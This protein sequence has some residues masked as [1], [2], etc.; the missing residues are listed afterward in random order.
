MYTIS[1]HVAWQRVGEEVIIIELKTGNTLG[2]NPTASQ[3]WS[4]INDS[5]LEAIAESIAST[6]ELDLETAT[7]D[8]AAFLDEM[9]QRGLVDRVNP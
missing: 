9:Q 7:R 6:Y 5:S 4:E 8:V 1:P 3:I 2:L